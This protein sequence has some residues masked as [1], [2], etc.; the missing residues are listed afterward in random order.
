MHSQVQTRNTDLQHLCFL[1]RFS[2][3]LPSLSI[4]YLEEA[5]APKPQQ[6]PESPSKTKTQSAGESA[7]PKQQ[8]MQRSSFGNLDDDP[9]ASPDMH[10]EHNHS[11]KN[12]TA[13]PT[14]GTTAKS[15]PQRGEADLGRTTSTFT[16]HAGSEDNEQTNG[17]TANDPPAAAGDWGSYGDNRDSGFS[18][19]GTLGGSGFDRPGSGDQGNPTPNPI[20][21]SI[22][23]GRGAGTGPEETV[24]IAMLPEKEGM[25]LFQHRNYEVKSVRRSSSVVRRYSDFVWLLDCLHKRY[26]FRLLPLLPPKR[27]AGKSQPTQLIIKDALNSLPQST[28]RTLQPTVSHF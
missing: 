15:H 1:T 26:P 3:D 19:S 8:K 10:T 27:V 5:K 9:W 11:N 22:G 24:T 16:T 17:R 21:R 2:L 14:N 13:P 7:T 18:N 25:F 12:G 4:P 6:A 28:A 20:G 23:T